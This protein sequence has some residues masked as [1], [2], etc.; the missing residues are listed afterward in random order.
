MIPREN[1]SS[2]KKINAAMCITEL[3]KFAQSSNLPKDKSK[4]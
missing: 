3:A 4:S 2:G 1:F